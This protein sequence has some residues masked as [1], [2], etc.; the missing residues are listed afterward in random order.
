SNIDASF[1]SWSNSLDGYSRHQVERIGCLRKVLQSI[2]DLIQRVSQG[3][4]WRVSADIYFNSSSAKNTSWPV[5]LGFLQRLPQ[6]FRVI[7]QLLRTELSRGHNR[8]LDASLSVGCGPSCD[9][10][11]KFTKLGYCAGICNVCF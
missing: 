5:S 3:R 6:R 1:V 9:L 11:A 2:F 4:L 10:S 7:R 8:R